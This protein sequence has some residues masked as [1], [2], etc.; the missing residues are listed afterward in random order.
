M[1][2]LEKLAVAKN[3]VLGKSNQSKESAFEYMAK[4]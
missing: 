3:I 4:A 1:T 2:L